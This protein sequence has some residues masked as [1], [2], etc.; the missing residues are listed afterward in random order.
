MIS[1]IVA[2]K[3]RIKENRADPMYLG[4]KQNFEMMSY[5]FFNYFNIE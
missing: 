3:E 1:I 2:S 5:F 4:L